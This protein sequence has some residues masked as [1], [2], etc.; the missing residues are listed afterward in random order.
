MPY[1]LPAEFKTPGNFP[2]EY[3][4]VGTYRP[5]TPPEFGWSADEDGP[6]IVMGQPNLLS[7][8]TERLQK[9]ADDT[10]SNFTVT[11]HADGF[12]VIEVENSPLRPEAFRVQ[13]DVTMGHTVPIVTITSLDVLM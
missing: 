13:F 2:E 6:A 1:E 5:Y 8:F 4:E 10:R 12:A 3:T 11:V 9:F 7:G